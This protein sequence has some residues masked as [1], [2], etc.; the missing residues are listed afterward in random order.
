[1]VVVPT[2]AAEVNCI[3][4]NHCLI[5]PKAEVFCDFWVLFLVVFSPLPLF[6]HNMDDIGASFPQFPNGVPLPLGIHSETEREVF[7]FLCFS[8][9]AN[10]GVN[11]VGG[12]SSSTKAETTHCFHIGH[13]GWA[14]DSNSFWLDLH[15]HM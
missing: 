9:I 13:C 6:V 15:W 5:F 1:M 8:Q 2:F 14:V 7:Q 3:G 11:S 12:L 10:Q 4:G